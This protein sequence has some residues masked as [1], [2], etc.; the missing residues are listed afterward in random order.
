MKKECKKKWRW[1]Y[2]KMKAWY[3]YNKTI[4]F[5]FA[6]KKMILN[7]YF[8][9]KYN[10]IYVWFLWYRLGTNILKTY[11]VMV[12]CLNFWLQNSFYSTSRHRY[13][14][15][16]F[17]TTFFGWPYINF[18]LERESEE[19]KKELFWWWIIKDQL[20]LCN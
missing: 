7:P 5:L 17:W 16:V 18:F 13:F 6:K 9:S 12:L 20:S 19:R 11:S 15:N 14:E 10:V 3:I 2:R 8:S 1:S 4:A